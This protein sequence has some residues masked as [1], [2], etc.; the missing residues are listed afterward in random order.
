MKTIIPS[1]VVAALIAAWTTGI[2]SAAAAAQKAAIT[3]PPQN[4]ILARLRKGHPRLLFSA[5]DFA[6]LKEQVAAQAQLK[7]WHAKLQEQAERILTE[8]PSRYE[9]PD[10]LRLLSTSRR[11]LQRTYTL[12]LLY[13][14]DGDRRY[15]ERA[16]QELEAAAKF[17]DWNP[18]HFLDTAEMT[19][20]FAI[21]YDWLYEA[22]TEPQ[23]AALR[24]AMLEK[25]IQLAVDSY[26]GTAKFGWWMKAHHNW[27]Q[28][29]N[30]GIGMGALALGDELPEVAG[31]FLH[32]ALQSLQLPMAEFAPD[33]AW[34]E[35][36]GYWNYATSYNVV[37]LAAL[38][39]ALGTDFGLSQ[40]PG[41]ADTGLFPIYLTGPLGR[42]FNY[43]D[44]GEG[45]IRAPQMFWLA[46]KFNR[47]AYAAYQRQVA[48][49]HPQDL[50]WFDPA[51]AQS[52][53]KTLPLDKV[54][55]GAEV[56]T[57]RSG[58]DD[59]QALFVGFKAGD[60]KANH[61]NLDL[62]T[63]VL[64][65]LGVRWALDLGADNYNMPGYFG[66]QRWTYYRMRA[67]GHNTLL[68]N[69][70]LEPDQD[71]AAAARLTRFQSDPQR[72]FAIA[73]LTPAYARHAQRVWRGLAL[74]HRQQVLVQDEVR[75]DKPA[76][77]WWFLHT[78][79]QAKVNEDGTT[80][81]LSQDNVRLWARILSP[82]KA[83]FTVM[84]A[85]PLPVSPQSDQQAKNAGVRK[86]AIHLSEQK[87]LQLRVWLAPLKEGESAPKDAP[88]V[89]ALAAW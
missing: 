7:E 60:N 22:W 59:R 1:L 6:R 29:C 43:A 84:D 11:V 68:L 67:E 14:L 25:G 37:F 53:D 66:K 5:S 38:E 18:R 40:M 47:P 3:I 80:A 52:Q 9:I 30:G 50:L 23:R 88:A 42:T 71:P 34:N 19:H 55:R 20:A 56:A 12:A 36:P 31:E 48:S 82:A 4:E 21:A 44:G 51:P 62:G 57:F 46:R 86:L 85:Q 8:S 69:P 49:P 61:S 81:I 75:A 89:S 76:D 27:N 16:W 13:R 78:R 77:V 63:F 73:D 2:V 58:W 26:R 87:D 54:F 74:L 72:A 64:D 17:P 79:A 32:G 83:V 33:G 15:V 70:G 35:G 45:T 65:A 28:V 24:A 10:G 41:F 39:S